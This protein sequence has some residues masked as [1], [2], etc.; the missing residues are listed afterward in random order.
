MHVHI[1]CLA[2]HLPQSTS[3]TRF[4]TYIHIVPSQYKIL[5]PKVSNIL[6]QDF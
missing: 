5:T 3:D 1:K 4:G 2:V 6:L